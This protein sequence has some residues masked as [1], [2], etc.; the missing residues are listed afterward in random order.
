MR[1]QRNSPMNRLIC[2]TALALAGAAAAPHSGTTPF[3]FDGNRT[4]AEVAF[5]RPDGSAHR[6]LVFVDMGSPTVALRESLFKDLKVDHGKPL[7]FTIGGFRIQVPA[8]DVVSEP[9]APSSLGVELKVEGILPASVMKDH[10]VVIDYRRRTLTVASPGTFSPLGVEVPFRMNE[11]TGLLSIDA[12]IDGSSYPLT[13][14]NG[15]AYTWVRQSTGRTWLTAH[16]GWERGVGAVGASNM[17]MSG[18]PIETA[19]TLLRIPRIAAGSLVLSDVGALAV[20]RGTIEGRD[21]FDWYSEKNAGPVAGWI[22]GNVLKAYRITIDYPNRVMYWQKEGDPDSHD[23]DQVGVTLKS[24]GSRFLV[25]AV[26]TKNGRPA[27]EGVLPGDR[28]IRIDALDT[29]GAT[30][31]AIYSALHGRPGERRVLTIERDGQRI[32]VTA[33]VTGF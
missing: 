9:R 1:S 23:L 8:A 2:A 13:I 4:Y 6:A 28:L 21:L 26:A 12:S 30:W 20:G 19:G 3:V 14:D 11:R 16:P 33:R 7:V 22:G 25:A 31:G 29:A 5:L 27:V 10:Q 17:M 18:T 24:E 15:S 32:S